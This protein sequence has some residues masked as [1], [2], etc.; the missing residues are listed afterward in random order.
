MNDA[1]NGCDRE[2]GTCCERRHATVGRGIDSRNAHVPPRYCRTVAQRI[3]PQ[4]KQQMDQI[5]AALGKTE[6]PPVG[7][8]STRRINGR[9]M[10]DY[11]ASNSI[12]AQG[13][14]TEAFSVKATDGA[15]LPA[16]W[17]RPA[18]G[19]P[20]GSAVLYLH[21]GGM[22]FSL[23]DIGQMYDLAIRRYVADSGVPMLVVDYRVAP[24]HP[25]PTPVEDCYAALRWLAG[26]ASTLGF[27]PARLAVMGDSAGG[28]LAAAVCLMA[29]DRGGPP[30][31]QQLLVYPMLD[32]RPAPRDTSVLRYLT[33]SYDDNLTGWGALLGERAGGAGVSS[34]AAPARAGDLSGL[35]P[36]FIDIGDLDIFR[37]EDID[38][39]RRLAD[40]RVPVEFHLHP[41][42]P[43]AFEALAD[44]ADVS[45]RAHD[46]RVRRLIS[47]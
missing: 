44:A 18:S 36:T 33:W 37:S 7:D 17:Y 8:V 23:A 46:D 26:M 3:D 25:D 11:I 9:R 42:C 20:R 2:N 31:A 5:T 43:H 29:R 45:R 21:G 16:T 32:D 39:A 35:P 47:L 24:E 28:G 15:E 13:V 14:V 34:Y 38:Y 27:D 22:I 10:F 12:P 4:V 19:E 1:D 30:V 41:G 40:A 6:E